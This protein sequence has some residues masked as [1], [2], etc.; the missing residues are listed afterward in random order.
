MTVTV[1][2]FGVHHKWRPPQAVTDQMWLA[3]QL[4]EDLVSIEAAYDRARAAAN[5]SY[6]RIEEAARKAEALKAVCEAAKDALDRAKAAQRTTKPDG[7][8]AGA[9]RDA[10]DALKAARAELRAAKAQFKP[11]LRPLFDKALADKRA[12]GK[13]TYARYCQEGVAPPWS[14]RP[15][16]LYWDT[17]HS[18][19]TAHQGAVEAMIKTRARGL[20]AQMRHHR[21]DGT[22]IATVSLR[23]QFPRGP[24][25]VAGQLPGVTAHQNVLRLAWTDP[26]EW[27]GLSRAERRRRGRSTARMRI[28]D[29]MVDLPVQAHRML[30]ADAEITGA[31]LVLKRFGPR[32]RAYLQVTARTPGP[33]PPG[34]PGPALVFH[35][36]W[37]ASRDGRVEAATWAADTPVRIPGRLRA[38]V[39][40]E[41]GLRGKV[42]VPARVTARLGHAEA[43]RATRDA[44]KNDMLAKV[45][46]TLDAHGIPAVT[47]PGSPGAGTGLTPAM[48]RRW[49]SPRR[50]ARLAGAWSRDGSGLPDEGWARDLAGAL[51]WWRGR[52]RSVWH[53]EARVRA[54]ATA[55]RDDLYRQVG[56]WAAATAGRVGLD[57]SALTVRREDPSRAERNPTQG[58]KT[59]AGRRVKASPGVLRAAVARACEHA[60]VAVAEVDAA[61]VTRMHAVC[62]HVN[63]APPFGTVGI[64]CGGCG[65]TYDVNWNAVAILLSRLLADPGPDG[66]AT[67]RSQEAERV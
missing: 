35:W 58:R 52:D 30:P 25:A 1:E 28:G 67:S 7:P 9:L 32:L 44:Q 36:G 16:K 47:D 61:Y 64:R 18:V 65:E 59:A 8:Q 26:A 33:P 29:E 45:A 66:S 39:V 37:R 21:F 6:P 2:T 48:I 49:R 46:D 19:M 14:D 54:R 4:R 23:R 55:Y 13:A 22:G 27:D 12:A 43:L 50:L 17:H 40:T 15:V 51:A 42:L 24:A 63:P 57:G 11:V 62:S 60:G 20:P 34:G 5:A 31:R 10:K 38:V 41:D 53:R 3:H 56:A